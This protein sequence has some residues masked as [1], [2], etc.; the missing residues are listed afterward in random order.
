MG[1]CIG[2]DKQ[3]DNLLKT[4]AGSGYE[5]NYVLGCSSLYNFEVA[6]I[7]NSAIM[8]K[9]ADVLDDDFYI[10]PV[11]A[12]NVVVSPVELWKGTDRMMAE[13]HAN[14]R[15]LITEIEEDRTKLPEQLM[16]YSGELGEVVV[17]SEEGKGQ[18]AG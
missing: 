17:V 10:T 12:D 11:C 18:M 4:G 16:M 5:S 14:I 7:F 3:P 15:E 1:Y 2:N 9:V 6:F 13:L 8:K